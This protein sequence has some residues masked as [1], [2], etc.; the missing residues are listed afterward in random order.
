M[1]SIASGF[2]DSDGAAA[3]VISSKNDSPMK[4]PRWGIEESMVE[5]AGNAMIEK[6]VRYKAEVV[7]APASAVK[8]AFFE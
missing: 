6:G 2:G 7:L 1:G 8:V 3:Q 4:L 5:K